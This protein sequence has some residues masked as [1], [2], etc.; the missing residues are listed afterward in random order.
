MLLIICRGLF[1]VLVGVALY[2]GLRSQPVPQVVSH[3]DLMLHFGAFFVM[4]ALWLVGFS[5][6][7]RLL[8]V[9]FL[10]LLG[11][12]IEFWQGWALP[13]RTA[14]EIDMLAN[15]LGVVLAWLIGTLLLSRVGDFSF[16]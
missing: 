4:S 8:G 12:G 3:F 13:G 1:L 2:A 11:I 15:F 9:F 7:W 6:R 14:S 10:L 5:R 16:K